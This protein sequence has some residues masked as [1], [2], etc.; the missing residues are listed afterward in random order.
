MKTAEEGTWKNHFSWYNGRKRIRASPCAGE[1]TVMTEAT[2]MLMLLIF[3]IPAVLAAVWI[4]LAGGSAWLAA[5]G[6][7]IG[8]ALSVLIFLV[9]MRLLSMHTD[10]SKP[11][12]KQNP[13]ARWGAKQLGEFLCFF[14]GV[15]PCIRGTEKLPEEGTF[16]FV[17]NHRSFFDPLLV[18]GYLARWNI[19]FVSKPSN[20]RIPL[21]SATSRTVGFL[22]IDRENDREALKTILTAADYMRRGVCSIGIYPE[23]TRSRDGQL[24]P[25]HKG[26]FKAAQRAGVPVAIACTCGSE[27]LKRGF[28]F[29]PHRVVLE[30]LEVIPAERV[31]A[32]STQELADRSS[33]L[34]RDWLD[35]EEKA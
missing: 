12:G 13:A 21:V 20:M 27:K 34:M 14:G 32:M 8:F 17:S 6:F 22:A 10:L 9:V 11:D 31:R 2:T 30:I 33:S 35:R 29:R 18:M 28:C 19:A 15:R 23:G 25:F 26:S 3:L 4:P 24:L 7:V 16:L 5:A 1:P